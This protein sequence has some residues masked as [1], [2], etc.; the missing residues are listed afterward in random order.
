MRKFRLRSK[1]L[2]SLLIVSAGLTAATLAVVSYSVKKSVRQSI[3]EQ[4]RSSITTYNTIEKQRGDALARSAELLANLPNVRAL[5]TTND[6]PTIQDEVGNISRLSG[7]D[8]LVLADRSGRVVG[9]R[10]HDPAFVSSDAQRLLKDSLQSESSADWW[11]AGGHLYQIRIQPI[12]F[13]DPSP[14]NTVGL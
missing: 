5:M 2:L 13:G 3:R 9:V 4:L 7:S 6:L 11:Y 12:Y 1:F 10:G 14:Q 8:V